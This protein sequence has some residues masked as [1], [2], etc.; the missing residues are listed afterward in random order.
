MEHLTGLGQAV[1]ATDPETIK[2]DQAIKNI[3]AYKPILAR[4]IKETVYE[5]RNMSFDE[6][7]DCIEG[8]VVI[9]KILVGSGMTNATER[10]DGLNTDAFLNDEGLDR[11]DIRTY[12]RIP[13]GNTDN[14]NDMNGRIRS[15]Q[16]PKRLKYP[17][18]TTKGSYIKLFI[19][20]EAQKEDKPGYDLSLR[21]LFY[22][23]RMIS[24]QQDVEFTTHPDDPVKYGNIKKVYSI[25]LCTDTAQKRANSIEKYAVK[26]S[27]LFGH[28][29]DTPRSDILAAI[30][31]NISTKPNMKASGSELL[32][33]MADLF[34]ETIPGDEKIQK[35]RDQHHLKVS[36]ALK[37]R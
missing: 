12:L 34:D 32:R 16:P 33:L 4:I 1:L 5:C 7:E 22:C 25:W 26:R 15:L 9:S 35:L 23:C 8:D 3:L 2:L 31:I 11:Y 13:K 14:T 28:N 6:I 21:A 18:D 37:R 10:I 24:A 30:L 19:N 20:V 29:P 17:N 27:F 36:P